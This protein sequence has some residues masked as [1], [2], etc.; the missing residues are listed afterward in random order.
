M[1]IDIIVKFIVF[2]GVIVALMPTF[3]KDWCKIE[4]ELPNQK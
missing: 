4:T 3:K 1:T 2:I